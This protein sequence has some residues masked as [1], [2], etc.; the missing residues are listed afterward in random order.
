[1]KAMR[2]I[3]WTVMIITLFLAPSFVLAAITARSTGLEASGNLAGLTTACASGTNCLAVII[4]KVL[5]A[6]LG[7]LGIIFLGLL[8]YA[9][10][11]WMT[12]GGE[13]ERAK[14]AR[15]LIANA[16]AG[17]I[18]IFASY[19]LTSYVMTQIQT[20]VEKTAAE[21]PG[22]VGGTPRLRP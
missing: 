9:G 6:A 11:L 1:M 20:A 14:Q 7:F 4:G 22:T 19:V 18:I 12:S 15:T 2:S 16:V 13:T 3:K 10:F 8:L 5:A 17:L 21:G